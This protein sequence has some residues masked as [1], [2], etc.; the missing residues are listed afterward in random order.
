MQWDF[1][2]SKNKA[3]QQDEPRPLS[4][5]AAGETSRQPEGE[6]ESEKSFEDALAE[7]MPIT[8]EKGDIVSG[9]VAAID[10]QGI[11]VDIGT[12]HEG[13]VPIAE[14]SGSESTPA[15]DDEIE[16]AVV[17]VDDDSNTVLLS[18]RRADYERVWNRLIDA[19]SSGDI[20]DAMVTERVKGGLR[21]DVGV[22]GFV[23]GSHVG[24]RNLRNLERFVGQSVRLRVLEADRQTKK[25]VLSHRLVIE[26]E[27][28]KRR[29]ETLDALEEGMVVDGKVR[30]LANYGAFVDLGGV[31]G[32][33][34]ISEMAWTRIKHPSD[35]LKVGDQIRVA[36]LDIDAE[37]DR[38]SLSRRQILPDPWKEAA[39]KVKVGSVVKCRITRP[40]RTGAFAQLLDF[41]IEGFI[42]IS[43][44][45][46]KRIANA[47]DV[48]KKDMEVD[49]KVMEVRVSA[50][51]MTLSLIAAEQ[52][53]ERREYREFM[54]KQDSARV[55]L[56][57]QFGDILQQATVVT[58]AEAPA[59]PAAE[60]EPEVQ[61]TEPEAEEVA[62]AVE[63]AA[64]AETAEVEAEEVETEEVVAEAAEE[65]ETE[66]PTAEPAAEAETAEV[67]AEEV[68]TEEVVAEAAEEAETEESD[69]EPADKVEAEE[70]ETEEVVAESA[71][72]AA[73]KPAPEDHTEPW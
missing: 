25:V 39:K 40:V 55:T 20:I 24:A 66:Q 69:A 62:V 28:Q 21:V 49:L 35:V 9:I 59:E 57:D 12:K 51:R 61:A 2:D 53:K 10:K 68:E 14:F 48:A 29:Q 26:E 50:R 7:A 67:E 41:D 3:E 58:E 34:H 1:D 65:A 5:S 38:I 63:P 71:E 30:S 56:G 54:D 43:E 31:D 44:L 4:D 52:E 36:V 46:D 42:P 17:K 33:L 70:V 47:D 37:N 19:V 27:R 8:V 11:I 18:K 23:P 32:L 16:V 6:T 15:V 73:E 60:V 72:A 64:E 45:S 13:M 22:P